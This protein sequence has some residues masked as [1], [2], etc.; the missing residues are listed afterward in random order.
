METR[1]GIRQEDGVAVGRR[2]RDDIGAHHAAGARTVLGHDRL[3]QAFAQPQREIAA[4]GVDDPA[5]NVR[6]DDADRLAGIGLRLRDRGDSDKHG[7][8]EQPRAASAKPIM[9]DPPFAGFM[10]GRG[11]RNATAVRAPTIARSGVHSGL[12]PTLRD[13][14]LHGG[15][16]RGNAG[17]KLIRRAGDDL[18]AGLARLLAVPP[19]VFIAA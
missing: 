10:F 15:N 5:G 6:Q 4:G 14:F 1:A 9:F 12:I 3:S 19:G 8:A 7:R 2:A 16:L 18:E 11:V 17:G 13:Q